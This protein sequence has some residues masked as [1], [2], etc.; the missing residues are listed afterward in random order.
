VTEYGYIAD[1][2]YDPQLQKSAQYGNLTHVIDYSS[3]SDYGS[4][5]P[6]RTTVKPTGQPLCLGLE[7]GGPGAGL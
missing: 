1:F 3:E 7:P 4:D 5:R 2:Q 6:Y